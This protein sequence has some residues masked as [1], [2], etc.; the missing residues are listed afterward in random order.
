[1]PLCPVKILAEMAVPSGGCSVASGQTYSLVL[2]L[3][4]NCLCVQEGRLQE[5][6]ESLLSLEKQ[7]RTVSPG[8][9]VNFFLAGALFCDLQNVHTESFFYLHVGFFPGFG[10]GVHIQDL[11]GH[12][13]NVPRGERLG[14]AQ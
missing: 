10:H 7:T 14:R 5:A 13:A 11:G 8:C 2:T 3:C 1:M 4:M 9:S 6:V 12:R